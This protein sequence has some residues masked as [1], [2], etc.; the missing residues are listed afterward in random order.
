[1]HVNQTRYVIFVDMISQRV[2]A[3]SLTKGNLQIDLMEP[4]QIYRFEQFTLLNVCF[5]RSLESIDQ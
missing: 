4:A 5:K 3:C 2:V 1:M